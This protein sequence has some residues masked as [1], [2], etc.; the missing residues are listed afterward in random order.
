M[1]GGESTNPERMWCTFCAWLHY[2]LL[3][4]PIA[5]HLNFL[6]F[7]FLTCT[8]FGIAA[9]VL[10]VW[11]WP[12]INRS[13]VILFGRYRN[14]R[15]CRHSVMEIS[16]IWP[17]SCDKISQWCKE[18]ILWSITS[19]MEKWKKCHCN[20]S[21]NEDINTEI[22]LFWVPKMICVYWWWVGCMHST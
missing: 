18:D 16:T 20:N 1:F 22:D 21:L 19:Y 17:N 13:W 2:W 12:I 14:Y 7:D 15:N 4:S 9:L 8:R 3:V 11:E 10:I 5:S 6:H